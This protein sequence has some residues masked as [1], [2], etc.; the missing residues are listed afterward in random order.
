MR[1]YAVDAGCAATHRLDERG[2]RT[3]DLARTRVA[4]QLPHGLGDLGESGGPD[5]EQLA[6][7]VY[8]EILKMI[9]MTRERSGEPWQ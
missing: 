9:E 6:Q 2:A 4:A 7:D 3:V 5:V 1:S 8:A